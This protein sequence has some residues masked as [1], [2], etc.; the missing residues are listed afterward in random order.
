MACMEYLTPAQ[1]QARGHKC[2]ECACR[3]CWKFCDWPLECSFHTPA[4]V[5]AR[6]ALD[7]HGYIPTDR[8]WKANQPSLN[9]GWDA[10]G[11]EVQ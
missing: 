11:S 9:P 7:G 6:E 2:G 8:E 3:E 4:A 5:L 1:I 10:N